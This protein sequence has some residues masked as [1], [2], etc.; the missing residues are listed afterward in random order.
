M[1]VKQAPQEWAQWSNGA[2]M[3]F[4]RDFLA[5]VK[6]YK[7]SVILNFGEPLT[8]LLALGFGLG[9]YVAKMAGVPFIDFIGPGLLAVT[10]MNAVT[11]DMAFEG[12]DRLNENRIYQSMITAPLTVGQ[13]V[14]GEYLWEGIRSLLYGAVFIVVLTALNLVKS[15]WALLLPLPLF[16]TGIMFAAPA[17]WVASSAKNHE[18]LFYYFTL[19]ITPMYLF[20][21]V[22]FPITHMPGLVRDVIVVTPLFHVVNIV[23]ALVLGHLYPGLWGDALWMIL[24]A[25]LFGLVP[26][27]VLG[28]RLAE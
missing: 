6:Y 25:V 15:W 10:A 4:R 19:F 26:V 8:N 1:A 14:A 18:Q 23:R 28:R 22:F 3:V 24:Y 17:L 27:R 20:S 7:S 2:L 16:V 5:W 11:F 9:T 21:G 13:I 12:Y